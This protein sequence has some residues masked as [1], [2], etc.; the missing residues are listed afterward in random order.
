[1]EF[2]NNHLEITNKELKKIVEFTIN[3]FKTDYADGIMATTSIDDT[4]KRIWD[5]FIETNFIYKYRDHFEEVYRIY[6]LSLS[7]YNKDR[8]DVV[9]S[10]L[11][12]EAFEEFSKRVKIQKVPN[13]TYGEDFENIT[14]ENFV[15]HLLK[16]DVYKNSYNRLLE[17][18]HLYKLFYDVNDYKNFTLEN[19]EGHVVNSVLYRKIFAKYYPDK[20]IP[21]AVKRIDEYQNPVYDIEE[22]NL[23]TAKPA[24]KN[25]IRKHTFE[26]NE[27]LLILNLCIAD[28]N[29]IPITE[30]S[31]LIILIGEIKDDSIFNEP[32]STNTTYDKIAKG[33]LRK[34]SSNTM[35]DLI[36]TIL[37]KID[38][39]DLNIAK[40]TLNM[41][42][43]T[44]VKEQN[45]SK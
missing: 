8:V 38:E 15:N 6:R 34:G 3:S 7:K 19:F 2:L 33:Y 26:L 45:N 32:S 11:K 23:P 35:I 40:Q 39:F 27:Q 20:I 9:K 28:R 4:R 41:H 12:K 30:K 42:R 13:Y 25:K 31:K 17:N 37:I 10:V 29:S 36:D 18:H 16:Y 22:L 14:Y 21:I 43:R 5:Q 1:M 24:I 44:L